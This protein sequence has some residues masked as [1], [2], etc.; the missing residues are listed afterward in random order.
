[1]YKWQ[2]RV[3][4]VSL[5]SDTRGKKRSPRTAVYKSQTQVRVI[6]L[7]SDTRTRL[8]IK[9]VGLDLAKDWFKENMDY[10]NL[11]SKFEGKYKLSEEL[12]CDE[13]IK[14]TFCL[15]TKCLLLLLTET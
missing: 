7:Q 14:E 13:D 5:Q 15:D 9:I 4:A 10:R 8:N 1:M 11:F 6:S 2:K 12:F 3:R